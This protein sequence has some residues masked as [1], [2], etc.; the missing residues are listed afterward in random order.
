M[1]QLG[2]RLPVRSFLYEAKLNENFVGLLKVLHL[3]SEVVEIVGVTDSTRPTPSA[4]TAL[5]GHVYTS[6]YRTYCAAIV[7]VLY[8]D[9]YG[10]GEN[11]HPG[12]QG[13]TRL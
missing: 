6:A 10:S 12:S 2:V 5:F 9:S 1:T 11:T 8:L 4:T 3:S 7:R 13:G